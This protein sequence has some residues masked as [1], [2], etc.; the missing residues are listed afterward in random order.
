[1]TR[2]IL[3]ALVAATPLWAQAERPAEPKPIE[4]ATTTFS[5]ADTNRDGILT[6]DELKAHR[7]DRLTAI[8]RTG[9]SADPQK[10]VEDVDT[11]YNAMMSMDT[12]LRM[13]EDDD[14]RITQ[15]EFDKLQAADL[16]KFTDKDAEVYGDLTFDEWRTFASARGDEFK[17][18]AFSERMD[19]SRRALRTRSADD[20]KKRYSLNRAN[21]NFGDFRDIVGADTNADG[22]VTRAESREY[23]RKSYNGELDGTLT[24]NQTRLLN[25][26]RFNER[27]SA[28]DSNDDGILT[29]DEINNAWDA[30]DD[31]A[32]KKL[33]ANSDNR[34]DRD[35][36]SSWEMNGETKSNASKPQRDGDT[37]KDDGQ[38]PGKDG[39]TP[40]DGGQTPKAPGK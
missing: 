21:S 6:F 13:D 16:P 17:V 29:R 10:A 38:T 25:E 22:M 33:D 24:E 1:M 31:D 12:F 18:S 27:T 19:L 14:N 5:A 36:I 26:A 40:K 32:W 35:E 8:R 3:A 9:D 15:A 4:K 37:P 7:S 30:P 39:Q 34:L 11:K 23:W 2:L 28:L 20:L